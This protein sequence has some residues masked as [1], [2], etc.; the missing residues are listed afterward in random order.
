MMTTEKK[1]R[2]T[3][4][5]S[6]ESAV[7]TFVDAKKVIRPPSDM[8]FSNIQTMIFSEI[9][10]EFANVDWTAHSIRLAATLAMA[11]AMLQEAQSDMSA[12]Q[13][14]VPNA[15]GNPVPNPIIS[16]INS[17]S[18]QVLGMRRSLALHAISG[19]NKVDVGKRRSIRRGQ[20]NDAPENGDD[21][22]STPRH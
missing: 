7:E 10:D 18:S 6:K 2:R 19:Q 9:I 15:K 1:T 8:T 17:L 20:Q 22:I 13:F 5:D 11:L 14:V 12:S 4:A 21:L 3:R 16:V